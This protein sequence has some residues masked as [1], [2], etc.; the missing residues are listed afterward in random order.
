MMSMAARRV[1][2]GI[3]QQI[4]QHLFDQHRINAPDKGHPAVGVDA[5]PF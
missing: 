5:T 3:F 1:F 4:D 2:A